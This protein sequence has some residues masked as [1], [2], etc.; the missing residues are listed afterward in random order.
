M[1]VITSQELTG[2]KIIRTIGKISAASPWHGCEVGHEDKF[3][4]Q[5]L[6]ALIAEAKEFEAN[7][8]LGV[9][10]ETR[11]AQYTDLSGIPVRQTRISGIAVKT[12]KVCER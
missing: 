5:A 12:A 7:A 2:A 3:R 10:Y 1:Q 8:I 9:S 6:A 11:D 4:D